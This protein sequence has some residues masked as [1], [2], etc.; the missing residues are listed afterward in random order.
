M[1]RFTETQK[2]SD[3]WFMD[4][5]L[6]AKL[7]WFYLLDN[8]DNSGVIRFNPKLA[9]VQIGQTVEKQH[10]TE[11]GDR[12]QTLDGGKLWI[13][14]F[15]SFQYGALSPDCRPHIAV[16]DLVAKHGLNLRVSIPHVKGIK[17][18]EDKEKDKE[19]DKEQDKKGVQGDLLKE[20]PPALNTGR[21][22]NKW[23]VWMNHRRAFKKPKS[24]VLLFNEQI[25][26]L[27][28]FDEPT[29]FEILSSSI[30]NGYQGLFEPK[31]N[32]AS[33]ND[34]PKVTLMQKIIEELP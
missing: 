4:L 30:R 14:A 11:L 19:K 1:K 10:F 32:G 24:W 28:K 8:C 15:I 26:W 20:L 25:E 9:A 13:P 6:V 5:S 34:K 33:Q 3:P 23:K 22:Q 7:L 12:L 31:S 2:W 17:T 27:S 29:A 21:I 18:L 16:M